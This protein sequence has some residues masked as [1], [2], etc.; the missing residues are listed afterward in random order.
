MK[1]YTKKQDVGYNAAVEVISH[2]G[3]QLEAWAFEDECGIM[4]SEADAN[5][6]YGASSLL[7]FIRT[8][9]QDEETGLWIW[10]H[11]PF[12]R[13]EE[14]RGGELFHLENDEYVYER[15]GK[16]GYFLL[17]EDVDEY[18]ESIGCY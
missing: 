13:R 10:K 15:R 16:Y 4:V 5:Y 9:E 2:T 17:E 18:L 11:E 3:A 6:Y 7:F 1:I 14:Y 8:D 12:Y